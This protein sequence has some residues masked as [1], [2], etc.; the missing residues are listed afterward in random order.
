[1][2]VRVWRRAGLGVVLTAA[3]AAFGLPASASAPS[4]THIPR[5]FLLHDADARKNANP[6]FPWMVSNR[7]QD[8]LS[9]NP[10]ET[11]LGPGYSG[12]TAVRTLTQPQPDGSIS[13]ELLVYRNE[14]WARRA[15]SQIRADLARCP[16]LKVPDGVDQVYRAR[17]LRLGDHGMAIHVQSHRGA[18]AVDGGTHIVLVQRGNAIALYSATAPFFTPTDDDSRNLPKAK[19]M[20]KKLCFY[21]GGCS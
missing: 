1:M 10:C 6:E 17:T 15:V 3:V 7:R 8:P 16:R 11:K 21:D 5:G 4:P 20:A 19:R 18:K 9:V 2:S 13:E 14:A 12:R